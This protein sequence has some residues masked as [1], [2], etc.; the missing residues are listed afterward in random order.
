MVSRPVGNSV[1]G[2]T[3]QRRSH[4]IPHRGAT[5]KPKKN[6]FSLPMKNQQFAWAGAR[7]RVSR[8]TVSGWRNEKKLRS[9]S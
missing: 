8:K 7:L 2:V 6:K 9:Q 5:R 1:T 3:T 4:D